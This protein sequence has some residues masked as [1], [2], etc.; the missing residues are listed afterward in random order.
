MTRPW[1]AANAIIDPA[2]T[3]DPITMAEFQ[4]TEA[5]TPQLMVVAGLVVT[6]RIILRLVQAGMG[7]FRC[8]ELRLSGSA[9]PTCAET[10]ED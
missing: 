1:P 4:G 7:G 10:V 2:K 3:S 5:A 9:V 8:G 6:N